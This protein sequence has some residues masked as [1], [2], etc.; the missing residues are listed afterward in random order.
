MQTKEFILLWSEFK[1]GNAKQRPRRNGVGDCYRSTPIMYVRAPCGLGPRSSF[2]VSFF[3]APHAQAQA[4]S[5]SPRIAL[6]HLRPSDVPEACCVLDTAP[7]RST[8]AAALPELNGELPHSIKRNEGNHVVLRSEFVPTLGTLPSL[9]KMKRQ[10]S[11]GQ[12]W[13][14]PCE[15]CCGWK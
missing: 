14:G 6:H 9:G 3:Y 11:V 4:L 13:T 2:P 8:T 7:V 10:L 1:R 5:P 15:Q 12:N